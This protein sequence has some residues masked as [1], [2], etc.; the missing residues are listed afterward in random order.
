MKS[1]EDNVY[2]GQSLIHGPEVGAAH[3]HCHNCEFLAFP[4]RDFQKGQDVLFAFPFYRKLD[5]AG[6]QLGH[7]GHV[8]MALFEA[9]PIDADGLHLVARHFAIVELQ[10]F[11]MDV[12]D[13]VPARSQIFG[14]RP[15]HAEPKRV[16]HCQ[17]RGS[18]IAVSLYRKGKR[19]PQERRASPV[20][21]TVNNELK[22]ARLASDRTH[23]EPALPALGTC[24]LA[25]ALRASNPLI[26]DL[27]AE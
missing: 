26:V 15:D 3:V 9:E 5:S 22:H 18:N 2:V 17:R 10:P 27:G 7:H 4:G 13:K 8:L 11:F 6:P 20:L 23:P 19:R 25:A 24:R 1:V 21:K 12:F 16:E 14:G